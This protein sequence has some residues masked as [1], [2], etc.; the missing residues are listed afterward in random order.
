MSDQAANHFSDH[1]AP[2]FPVSVKGIV[3]C[4]ERYVLLKNERNEWELPGGKLEP[5]EQPQETV[6]REIEEELSIAVHS[7]IIVDSWLYEVSQA[8]RSQQVLIVTYSV[9]TEAGVADCILSHEHKELA[10]FSS[11][12]IEGLRM[13]AGYKQSIA[14]HRGRR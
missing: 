12:Q 1:K 2:F 3:I 6:V 10:F 8:G 7:P 13:P 5:G 4:E 9:E 14:T 11:D